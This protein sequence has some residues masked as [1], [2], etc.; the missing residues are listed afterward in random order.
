VGED[1]KGRDEG[2]LYEVTVGSKIEGGGVGISI[3]RASSIKRPGG[4]FSLARRG[5][6]AWQVGGKAP[7]EK[8]VKGG[9]F[10]VH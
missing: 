9:G 10:T 2:G 5:A 1:E 3:G 7:G 4:F 8:G 6:G